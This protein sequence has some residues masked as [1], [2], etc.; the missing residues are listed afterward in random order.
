MGMEM[1]KDSKRQRPL[2]TYSALFA[3]ATIAATVPLA[4]CKDCE[5]GGSSGAT[6]SATTSAS[7]APSSNVVASA[8][9]SS[10][11]GH[12]RRRGG[13]RAGGATGALFGAAAGLDLKPEQKTTIDKIG[14]DLHEGG[15]GKDDNDADGGSGGGS[16]GGGSSEARSAMKEAHTELV[17]GVKAGKIEPAK[18]EAHHAVIEKAMK[19]RQGKEADALN[20][21][22]AALEPAQRTAA[23]ASVRAQ[24]EKRA[25]RMKAHERPDAGARPNFTRM[26]LERYTKELDLDA[27]QT[28]KAQALLPKDDGKGEDMTAMRE[29]AKK[30]Q[31]AVLAAFEKDGFDAK[32]LMTPVDGKKMR[33]PMEAE[34]KFL[35]A[36]IAI[37]KPEQREKLAAR[38]DKQG[39]EHSRH[40]P[41]GPWGEEE[42]DLFPPPP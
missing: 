18:I 22:Y 32:K 19:A 35:T 12:N 17:N 4:A 1:R 7:A 15:G 28:K 37:L 8:S 23:V 38:I 34:M 13:V 24:E 9:A 3:L 5:G 31:D 21:L 33:G 20:K 11:S 41:G 10:S 36:Y 30:H 42:E 2:R 16:G 27:E 6:P 39:G 40:R 26:K 29:E 25:A 14:A